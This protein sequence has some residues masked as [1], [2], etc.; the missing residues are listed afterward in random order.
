MYMEFTGDFRMNFWRSSY[1]IIMNTQILSE[2]SSKDLVDK[3]S[4]NKSEKCMKQS[5]KEHTLGFLKYIST[6]S[7]NK[8]SQKI[9]MYAIEKTSGGIFERKKHLLRSSEKSFE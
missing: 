6:K 4:E 1:E 5:L 2:E 9:I 3:C 8:S 7:S